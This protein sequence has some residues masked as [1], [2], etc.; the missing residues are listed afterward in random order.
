MNS[1]NVENEQQECLHGLI[2][3]STD[4]GRR[5]F[6]AIKQGFPGHQ[7]SVKQSSSASARADLTSGLP[8]VVFVEIGNLTSPSDLSWI[9]QFLGKLR[10]RYGKSIRV[11]CVVSSPQKFVSAGDL[12]F[13]NLKDLTPSGLLDSMIISPPPGVPSAPSIEQQS[14]D[15][16]NHIRDLKISN[17]GSS[18]PSLWEDNWVPVMCSPGSRDVWLRWLPR[19]ARYTN[20][21]PLIV[22]PTG[23]GKTRLAAAIHDLSQRS[24]PFVSITPRDFSSSELVQAEL[25][26]AVAGAYTG[27]VDKWGLVK[28]AEKGTLFIDELQSIDRDLQGKLITFIEN[29]SYRRVGEA[30]SNSADVRFVFATNRPLADLVEDGCLRDDFAYRLERLKINL[31]PIS[32]RRL[33]IAAAIC[34]G[35][36][37]VLRERNRLVQFQERVLEGLTTEAYRKLFSMEWPGNLRQLENT[38]AKLVE[39]ADISKLQLIDENCTDQTLGDLLGHKEITSSD[40]FEK[41]AIQTAQS[42]RTEKFTDLEDCA[43][44]LKEKI[45][46]NALTHTGGEVAQAAELVGDSL[47]AMSLFQKSRVKEQG[48]G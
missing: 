45:R 11:A 15:F 43:I 47:K 30:E 13:Q 1:S 28:R 27:A 22:G 23:S 12:L 2:V 32:E 6:S 7:V 18:L 4:C 20:E 3:S 37:K 19:Y 9:R 38:I 46:L 48:K 24:G 41:S 34:F 5:I 39:V 36:A 31:V 16:V 44:S 25:F 14:V 26:G 21:N 8:D 33:D 29:K 10:E 35:L 40:I 17:S 42:S